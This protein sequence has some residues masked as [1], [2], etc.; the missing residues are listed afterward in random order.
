M[1]MTGMPAITVMVAVY[2]AE[3]YIRRCLDSIRN[4][5]FSDIEVLLIDDG[6]PDRSGEICD[7]YS[8]LDSRFRV[9][10][11]ENGGV[12]SARQ[13][14]IDNARGEY[15][16]HI[17]PD[18]WI[19]LEM[20]ERMHLKAEETSADMVICNMV[21]ERNGISRVSTTCGDSS[22]NRLMTDA[23]YITIK[24]EYCSCLTNKLIRRSCYRGLR[25]PDDLRV[26]ED[27]YL[28]MRLLQRGVV[29][30]TLAGVYYHYDMSVND[31]SLTGYDNPQID[32]YVKKW[33]YIDIL[34]NTPGLDNKIVDWEIANYANSI[35]NYALM[36]QKEFTQ[37]FGRFRWRV[38][39]S[40]APFH[41]RV[42][43]F[44][45]TLGLMRA[46]HRPYIILK[47]YYYRWIR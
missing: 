22:D 6:S 43:V 14:G 30:A 11:K 23:D 40:D 21:Q 8:M 3:K 45:S 29:V 12:G 38:L 34:S 10:H 33:A 17:D 2:K 42:S 47:V 4:Q 39:R 20:L 27:T 26:C 5:T 28:L 1:G 18:D 32:Y 36:S 15:T 19:E 13:C 46:I 35:F 9:F 37:K 31:N 25:F 16:I 41:R 7:E 24:T 44:L